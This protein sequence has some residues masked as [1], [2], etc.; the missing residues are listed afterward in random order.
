[1]LR[2]LFVVVAACDAGVGD[3]E[4]GV[5][6][7]SAAAA[8]VAAQE[9]AALPRL[10]GVAT[11]RPVDEG[12][13]DASFARFRAELLRAVERRDSAALV[14]VLVP[15]IRLSF[16]GDAGI[17][18]FHEW[19]RPGDAQSEI[20]ATLEAVLRNGGIFARPEQ[21][22]TLFMAP[23]VYAAWP[24]FDPFEHVATLTET[25]V[26]RAAPADSARAIGVLPHQIV[27]YRYDEQD[28]PE[29]WTPIELPDGTRGW[30]RSADVYS[31]VGYRAI[32][33]KQSG[34]WRMITLIAGD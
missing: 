34:R 5:A 27:R 19:W 15:E 1:M 14:D 22:D 25:A 24:D 30:M 31:P 3:R 32:F 2:F 8:P 29:D 28:A 11:F 10:E 20:W 23:Y 7:T 21:G 17:A 4:A 16:G 9:V 33:A 6:D 18:S 13:A 12:D 26:M